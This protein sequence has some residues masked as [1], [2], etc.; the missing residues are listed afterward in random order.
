MN[1]LLSFTFETRGRR[2]SSGDDYHHVRKQAYRRPAAPVLNKERYLLCNCQ[3]VLE[4]P[5]EE[6]AYLVHVNDPN[7]LINWNNVIQVRVNNNE[8]EPTICCICL[9]E[10]RAARITKCGHGFCFPCILKY[11]ELSITAYKCPVCMSDFEIEEEMR[12]S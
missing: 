10:M 6:N 7:Q 4:K 11:R 2:T 9:E 8:R 5:L 12:Y 3:F 1:H